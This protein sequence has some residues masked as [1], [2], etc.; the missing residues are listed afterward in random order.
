MK[1]MGAWRAIVEIADV[2]FFLF[3][4]FQFHK[5]WMNGNYLA[6][7]R[8]HSHGFLS[9]KCSRVNNAASDSA[10]FHKCLFFFSSISELDQ[11]SAWRD[12]WSWRLCYRFAAWFRPRRNR[13]WSRTTVAVA[14]SWWHRVFWHGRASDQTLISLSTLWL[15]E[16]S[17]AKM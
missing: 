2:Y 15:A 11:H 3:S 5:L 10:Q 7:S 9:I 6:P 8:S 4:P 17:W 1:Q 13:C 14:D 12:W 16:H